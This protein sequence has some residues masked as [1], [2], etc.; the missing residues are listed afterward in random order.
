MAK[1]ESQ[2]AWGIDQLCEGLQPGIEGGVHAMHSKW[3][4]RKMEEKW[5]FLLNEWPSPPVATNIMN[6]SW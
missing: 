1:G 4:T 6:Y 2:D 5:G 3:E